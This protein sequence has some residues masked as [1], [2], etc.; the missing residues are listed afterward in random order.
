MQPWNAN[1]K[2][3]NTPAGNTRNQ[4]RVTTKIN[5][6]SGEETTE[7]DF[8][9]EEK[10]STRPIIVDTSQIKEKDFI[11]YF[12]TSNNG[13]ITFADIQRDLDQQD[14]KNYP[15]LHFGNTNTRGKSLYPNHVRSPSSKAE[16]QRN[17]TQDFD[18]AI[19]A[20]FPKASSAKN[21]SSNNS[22]LGGHATRGR[23]R[24]MMLAQHAS[25]TG[26]A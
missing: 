16:A 25:Q 6:C 11:N 10:P 4:A 13:G 8:I 24:G 22:F 7:D 12:E 5:H 9:C 19:K 23:G 1:I 15:A 3:K 20:P 18:R 21:V 17:W 14:N 26:F 2:N